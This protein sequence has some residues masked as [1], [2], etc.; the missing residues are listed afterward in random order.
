M[1][2]ITR[3]QRKATMIQIISVFATGAFHQILCSGGEM[4]LT[5]PYLAM[6]IW[7]ISI[8]PQMT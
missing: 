2:N 4:A 1:M 5:A 8:T 7:T 3:P 6:G